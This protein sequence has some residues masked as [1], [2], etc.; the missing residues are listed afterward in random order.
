MSDLSISFLENNKFILDLQGDFMDFMNSGINGKSNRIN[1]ITYKV[2]SDSILFIA[3]KE[4]NNEFIQ[5]GTIKNIGGSYDFLEVIIT[6][7][8]Q[9]TFICTLRKIGNN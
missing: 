8:K 5:V 9:D 7:N 2:E 3:G 1:E 4:N 6:E